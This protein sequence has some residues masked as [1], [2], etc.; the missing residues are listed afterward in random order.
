M[1]KSSDSDASSSTLPHLTSN[2]LTRNYYSYVLCTLPL[3]LVKEIIPF[4]TGVMFSHLGSAAR[5]A[6][7]NVAVFED[8]SKRVGHH[9]AGIHYA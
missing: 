6:A 5:A 1:S 9:M 8:F 4:S 7:L 2:Q 3:K